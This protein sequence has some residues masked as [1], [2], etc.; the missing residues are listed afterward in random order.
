MNSIKIIVEEKKV[1]DTISVIIPVYNVEAYIRKSLESV[2]R[3]SYKDL[4][5]IIIDDGSTDSSGI[6]CDE[7][8]RKDKRII[9]KHQKN[10][11]AASAKN[12]G[13]K[14][15]NGEY[16]AFLDSDDF[17]ELDAYEI[18]VRELNKY[19]ADVVQCGFYKV[20]KNKREEKLDILEVKEFDACSYLK[21]FTENWTCGL[22]W[23]KLYRRRIFDNIYFEE[24]HKI[25]DE[26][27]TYKGIMNARKI[28]KV[29]Y[30]VYDYRQRLSSVMLSENS[31]EKIIEDTL[32]YLDIRRKLVTKKFPELKKV[33]DEH[34]LNMLLILSKKNS[35][36]V[37]GVEKIKTSLKNYKHEANK[38]RIS[39]ALWRKLKKLE[40]SSIIKILKKRDSKEKRK[41]I[42]I[43]FK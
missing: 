28:I 25:D 27:F 11:G 19:Q 15:A 36:S 40:Y 26:F 10:G 9:V 14:I 21:H 17:L 5:I 20:Y 30:V 6:I 41:N 23:D 16:L 7:Y 8:A 35:I 2:C 37:G 33:F 43:Y 18:M 39:F 22:L 13:L 34:Y 32:E 12:T 3:Q 1:K 42:N 31:Q 24:G 29:P 38:I 4:E